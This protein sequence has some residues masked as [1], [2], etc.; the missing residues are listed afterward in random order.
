MIIIKNTKEDFEKKQ[1]KNIKSS[2]KKK[3]TKVEKRPKK[4]IKILM[5]SK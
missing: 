2:L 3:T 4:D 5:K 1:V